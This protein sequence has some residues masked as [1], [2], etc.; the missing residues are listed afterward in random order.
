MRALTFVPGSKGTLDVLEVPDPR[1]GQ[2]ELL[3][4][5]LALGICGTD[6]E[7]LAADYG[8]P[9]PG[10]ERMV[11]GH[12]SLGR[13][14][15]AP[16]GS[17]FSPGDLVVGVVRRPDPVPCGACGRGE[18]D[19]CRNGGYTERGI[20]ELD[21]FGSER[22]TVEAAYAVKV[23]RSLESV[24]VLVEPASV[25]AKAW[26]Q[27]ERIGAR[28]WFEPRTLLVT[29]AGPIGLLAALLGRQ[30]GLEVHVLDRAGPGL[31]SSLVE[32][33]G[34]TYHSGSSLREFADAKPDIIIECTGAGPLV[35]DSM[36]TTAAVGIVCLCGLSPGGRSH[37]VDAGVINRDIVLENDVIFGTVNGN[38]RHFR[39]AAAALAKAE[40][41][42]LERL[43]TRRVPLTRAL[44]GFEP[45]EHDVKTVI[46]LTA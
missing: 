32:A 8:W 11:I 43:I 30:R 21:G 20:K 23:D 34:G 24:G 13:V 31:K 39:D 1:P 5:G 41:A 6:R 15:E 40:P 44:E 3:V 46:D 45:A 2:G 33:M 35:I 22:W 14:L 4:E 16:D 36:T 18:F 28:S 27:I 10:E 42:W 29:G 19:M 7:L 26:E 17:A 9:P 25:V 12:E 38:L 37:R